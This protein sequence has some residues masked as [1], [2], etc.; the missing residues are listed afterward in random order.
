MVGGWNWC[1]SFRHALLT[2]EMALNEQ[3]L[4]RRIT[5]V[6]SSRGMSSLLL[7]I[8]NGSYISRIYVSTAAAPRIDSRKPTSFIGERSCGIGDLEEIRKLRMYAYL[9]EIA[10]QKVVAALDIDV[11]IHIWIHRY[12]G[13]FQDDHD[14]D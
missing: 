7:A 3:W 14:H 5:S 6:W 9:A 2:R 8:A 10:D 13:Q 1:A 11:V 4:E 12:T